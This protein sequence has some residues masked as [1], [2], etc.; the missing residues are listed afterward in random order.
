[1]NT[2]NMITVPVLLVLMLTSAFN[3]QQR[4]VLVVEECR[5]TND[6]HD[7]TNSN[8]NCCVVSNTNHIEKEDTILGFLSL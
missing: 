5:V 7:R 6:L 8:E 4:V 3:N 1:M 2:A